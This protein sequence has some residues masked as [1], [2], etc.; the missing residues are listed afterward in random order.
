MRHNK[1]NWLGP[2]QVPCLASL[3]AMEV[4]KPK[5]LNNFRACMCHKTHITQNPITSPMSHLINCPLVNQTKSIFSSAFQCHVHF[6]SSSLRIHANATMVLFL[7]RSDII[8]FCTRSD[9]EFNTMSFRF[10]YEFTSSLR[11]HVAFTSQSFWFCFGFDLS[12]RGLL[13]V[14][15]TAL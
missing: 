7:F 2:T 4:S 8:S 5:Q 6:T 13:D 11:V 9:F 1:E 3:L 14:T 10:S 12:H 15:S